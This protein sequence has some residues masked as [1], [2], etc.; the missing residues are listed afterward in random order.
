MDLEK[1]ILTVGGKTEAGEGRTI[2]LNSALLEA[3][4]DNPK[5]CSVHN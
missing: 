2:P 1:A 5:W 3:M 4:I